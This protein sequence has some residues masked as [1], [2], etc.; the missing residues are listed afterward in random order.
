M[1][2]LIRFVHSIPYSKRKEKR[3]MRKTAPS[4]KNPHRRS[5]GGFFQPATPFF[6]GASHHIPF[7]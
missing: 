2:L 4:H 1:F 3:K 6:L 5:D 7:V